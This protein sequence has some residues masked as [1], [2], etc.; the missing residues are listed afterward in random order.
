MSMGSESEATR[1]FC[2][3]AE[4]R[5]CKVQVLAGSMFQS[6][7]P[8]RYFLSRSGRHRWLEFKLKSWKKP[9]GSTG[10]LALFGSQARAS[11]DEFVRAICG[12]DSEGARVCV[13]HEEDALW[14]LYKPGLR[15][16]YVLEEGVRGRE[17]ILKWVTA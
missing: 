10:W 8:D 6:G 16:H 9:P 1:A 17:A 7:V 3:A 12:R 15:P 13:A 11:Q 2:A 4:K 14:V 5:G